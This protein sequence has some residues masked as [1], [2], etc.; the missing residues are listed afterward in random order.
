[1]GC[2]PIC[3]KLT[4]EKPCSAEISEDLAIM[5]TSLTM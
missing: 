1:L 4:S 3:I 2:Q 5:R